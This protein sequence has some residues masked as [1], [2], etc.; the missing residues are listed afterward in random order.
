LKKRYGNV[1]L[2]RGNGDVSLLIFGSPTG[3]YM[4]IEL[5]RVDD[6]FHMEARNEDGKVVHMDA[7]EKIGGH[8]NGVR[9]MQLLLMAL[10]G[11]SAI[12]IILILKKQRQELEDLQIVVDGEREQV[13]DGAAVFEKID[14][15]FMMKG[16]IDKEKAERAVALSMEK[17]CSV[18]KTLEKTAKITYTVVINE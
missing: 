12:D 14:V 16:K 11:C 4:R 5:K 8:N 17:Y 1:L 10:G 3:K 7:A 6:A 18:T 9:P 13:K 15:K 2:S